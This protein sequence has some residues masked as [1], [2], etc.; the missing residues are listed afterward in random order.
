MPIWRWIPEL[1]L[2]IVFFIVVYGLAQSSM[3]IGAAW[4]KSFVFVISGIA[5][6]GL[7]LLWTRL[8]EREWRTDT[9]SGISRLCGGSVIGALFFCAVAG[10]LAAIGAY[11]GSYASPHWVLIVVNLCFYFLVACGEEVLFRGV[12]FRLIDER[13]GFWW[14]M[15]LSSLMFGFIHIFQPGATIWS[16]IAIAVEAGLLLGAAYKWTG[17]LW[18]PIG[19]HL[20]WNFIQGNVFGFSVSGGG[21]EE[22]ILNA[23]VTGPDI[24]T[25]GAFGPEASVITAV[26]GALLSGLFIYAIHSRKQ[27]SG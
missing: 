14:A 11:R 3:M 10:M 23:A 27:S 7:F 25:G 9:L 5:I 19:I 18:F 16:S 22:S 4:L 1:V 13:F 20:A 8:F 21:K 24:I 6:L 2:G 17:T 12:L 15:G 26:L